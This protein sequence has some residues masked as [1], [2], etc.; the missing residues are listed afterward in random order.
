[1]IDGTVPP[2]EP[3][4][5]SR[6]WPAELSRMGVKSS[7]GAVD[8]DALVSTQPASTSLPVGIG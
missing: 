3:E 6:N 1:V 7:A 8:R 2:I 4:I 5:R